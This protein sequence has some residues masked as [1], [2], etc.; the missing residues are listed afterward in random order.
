[1]E[2]YIDR[3][4]VKYFNVYERK[5]T[6]KIYKIILLLFYDKLYVECTLV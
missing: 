2:R 1:M 5:D 6:M 4:V 3:H